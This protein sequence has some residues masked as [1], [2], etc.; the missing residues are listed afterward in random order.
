MI[1]EHFYN[2][3]FIKSQ[4]VSTDTRNINENDIFIALK[5][6]NFNGNKYAIQA[7]EKGAL[8]AVVDEVDFHQEGKTFLVENCL[9]F[10]QELASYHR[11]QY[12]IPVIGITG[13]NGKTTTKE[14]VNV[15]LS[16]TYNVTCTQGNLNNHI[17]VPL[18]LFNINKDTEIAV[19]EMGANHVGEIKELC[20][21]AKPTHGLI[22]SIGKAHLDGFGSFENII[23][24]KKELFDYCKINNF[25]FFSN[26]TDPN[27]L[28]FSKNYKNSIFYN[29][30]SHNKV[31]NALPSVRYQ[32]FEKNQ[33]YIVDTNLF[34]EYNFSNIMAATKLATHFDV[35]LNRIVNAIRT[36]TPSNI[37]SQ[38]KK[39][40]KNNLI[41]DAYNANPTSMQN[42]VDSFSKVVSDNK[43]VILGHMAE[44]GEDSKN[45]HD[46]LI[47]NVKS[48]EFKK[49]ILVGENFKLVNLP[50]DIEYFEKTESLIDYLKKSKII[51]FDV[52]IKGSRSNKLD[53]IIEFL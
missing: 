22:I 35:P 50:P 41:I 11:N 5:G 40:E 33:L 9:T 45:E 53:L 46:V 14:L 37:R 21:I 36:Y 26:T 51:G 16:T 43:M 7:V 44:L 48:K 25:N 49:V 20:E 19:V 28:G 18:T 2:N 47:R 34:G 4:S 13:T 27:I 42:A 12:D 52:L 32:I 17:G 15:C 29:N 31:L 30:H 24:T 38:I 3:Y 1:I 39:T 10:L 23:E 8:V 6:E